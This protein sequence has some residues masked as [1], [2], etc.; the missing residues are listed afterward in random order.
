MR[1]VRVKGFVVL[2]NLFEGS[3]ED[4]RLRKNLALKSKPP[5]SSVA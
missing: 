3:A 1:Q 2:A 4:E 5:I